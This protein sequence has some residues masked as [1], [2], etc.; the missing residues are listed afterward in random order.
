MASFD[1]ALNQTKIGGVS[2]PMRVKRSLSKAKPKLT[3]KPPKPSGKSLNPQADIRSKTVNSSY[4]KAMNSAHKSK[5]GED[6]NTFKSDGKKVPY[7]ND[8]QKFNLY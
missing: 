2:T 7:R 8:R 4:E 1:S 3:T 5:Y 6:D